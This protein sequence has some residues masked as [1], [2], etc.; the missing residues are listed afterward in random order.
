MNTV[1]WQPSQDVSRHLAVGIKKDQYSQ[2]AARWQEL[3][4]TVAATGG[5]E[6][7][8]KRHSELL[9]E[10]ARK[11]KKNEPATVKW[12]SDMTIYHH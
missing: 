1:R 6:F 9:C 7:L 11:Q 4:M 10:D 3:Q 12:Q 2:A 5:Y 8:A